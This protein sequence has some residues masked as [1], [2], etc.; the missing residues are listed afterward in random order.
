MQRPAL[1]VAAH[2]KAAPEER[3]AV[4]TRLRELCREVL[5]GY[6]EETRYGVPT[7]ARDGSAAL[8]F[9]SQKTYISLYIMKKAGV[10]AHRADL[11]NAGKGCIRYRRPE[12]SDFRVVERLLK[13]TITSA[14]APC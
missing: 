1:T 3:R 6:T 7:Y 9:A 13:D 4:L 12:H 8:A 5:S 10:D 14:E 2:L 11:P